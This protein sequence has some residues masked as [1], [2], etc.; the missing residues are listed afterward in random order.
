MSASSS[1]SFSRRASSS[2][3]YNGFEP[4]PLSAKPNLEVSTL[5][6]YVFVGLE[7]LPFPHFA[8]DLF[9]SDRLYGFMLSQGIGI[10]DS[11]RWLLRATSKR[12]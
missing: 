9:V 11:M 2:Y 8:D 6:W 7:H 1:L 4:Q 3:S 5:V 12:R 10:D